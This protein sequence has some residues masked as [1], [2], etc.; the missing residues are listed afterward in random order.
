MN[1][2]MNKLQLSYNQPV[3]TDVIFIWSRMA[4]GRFVEELNYDFSGNIQIELYT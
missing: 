1:D 4:F 3:I 2:I